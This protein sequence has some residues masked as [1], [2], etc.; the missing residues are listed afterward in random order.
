MIPTETLI[1]PDITG[2]SD[3]YCFGIEIV[4]KKITTN[5]ASLRTHF[6]LAVKNHA[7]STQPYK[8]SH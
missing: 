4:L 7:L 2:K 6:D 8:I 1:I 5:T 3:N